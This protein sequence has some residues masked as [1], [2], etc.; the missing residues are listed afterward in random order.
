MSYSR[1]LFILAMVLVTAAWLFSA[2]DIL[3]QHQFERRAVEIS[4]LGLSLTNAGTLGRPN[5]R[6]QPV[7]LPSMEF[8]RGTGTEHLFEA[9]IWIGARVAGAT[10]VS[11]A[12]VTDPAGYSTGKAGYEFTNDGRFIEERSTFPDSDV[13]NPRAVSHQD[14]IAYFTDRN[15]IVNNIPISGH[16][17]PLFADVRMESY[18]WNF[19]F[20]EG[21]SILRYD[22]TND[23]DDLWEDVYVA[24]YSDMVVR[25][26]NTTTETGSDFFNK[27]G[28][29]YLDE[30]GRDDGGEN[31][32]A[33]YVF[34]VGS[35]DDP[36]FN[37]YAASAV[38]GSEYRDIEFHPRYADLFEE[39]LDGMD[40]EPPTV[41]PAFWQ[42]SAG[43][44]DFLRPTDDV[45]RYSRMAEPWPLE[46]NRERL[47]TDG[48]NADG[49]YIQLHSIGPFPEVEPGETVTVYMAMVAAPKPDEYQGLEG[50]RIDNAETRVH[51]VEA[52][53]WAFQVFEGQYDTLS[54]ERERY[55]VPEPPDVP[56][57]HV[58]LEEGA[59]VVY[60]DRRA[61]STVDPILGEVDF[62]GYRIY[63]SRIGDDLRGTLSERQLI[64][65]FDTQDSPIGYNTGFDEVLI[66][67]GPVTFPDDDTEYWYRYRIEGMLSG[68]QYSFSVTAFDWGGEGVGSLET[69]QTANAVNVFPGT[70]PNVGFEEPVGVY[71]NPY[72]VSAAWDGGTSFTR[73]LTF[74]NLPPHAELTVYTL[75]GEVVARKTHQSDTY[76]GD[77]RWFANLSD[78]DPVMSGGEHHWDLLSDANQDLTTGLYLYTVKDLDSGD[79]QRGKLAIIK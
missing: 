70:P 11:T 78:D 71:P 76:R 69:S 14:L 66:P 65:E 43:S 64:R 23:S 25:N 34:D 2:T 33:L 72:R 5:V 45:D 41:Q 29:G 48:I 12:A 42:F 4:D 18:N 20:A 1:S 37:T 52:V 62:A 17:Q 6:N 13:F 27:N 15:T 31:L 10:R 22:I 61:E 36:S 44:G 30:T 40:L 49:N 54:R 28:I 59:A 46:Q 74:Y 3:A 19:G 58:E 53:D 67:D 60:W 21:L 16:D 56:R 39:E 26:V 77:I 38:L 51:L 63:R 35:N 55:L 75:A 8:P 9:G 57:I 24:M 50:K 32:Y 68:W 79:I 73:K 7:G 47:R